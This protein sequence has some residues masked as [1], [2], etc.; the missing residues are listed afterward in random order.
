MTDLKAALTKAV[1]ELHK[2]GG[3]LP[4][5]TITA[6][7]SAGIKTASGLARSVRGAVKRLYDNED[8]PAF[9]ADMYYFIESQFTAAWFAGMADNGLN[10]DEMTEEWA[11]YLSQLIVTEQ[12]FIYNFAIEIME[13]KLRGNPVDQFLTRADLWGN[14]YNEIENEARLK[15]AEAGQKLVWIY[16]DTDHCATCEA[17]NGIVAFAREWDVAGVKPQN[18]PNKD[19]TCGG[20]RCQCRLEPTSARHTRDAFGK[21]LQAASEAGKKHYGPGAHPGTGTSQDVH[22]GGALAI[23]NDSSFYNAKTESAYLY[24]ENGNL[25]FSKDGGHDVPFSKEEIA[26]MNNATL[27]HNHPYPYPS[28]FSFDDISMAVSANL[29]EIRAASAAGVW[30]FERPADGWGWE[31]WSSARN[32]FYREQE[33]WG[34]MNGTA[35]ETEKMLNHIWD[36]YA[37]KIGAHHYFIARK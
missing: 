35:E 8:M 31:T 33:N 16:G 18:A 3:E 27:T 26:K 9:I 25:V 30:V 34:R 21:I 7:Y 32:F 36:K 19:L 13:A 15:T 4:L 1:D 10:K 5:K 37:E 2:L 11:N 14:R 6:L 17:L 29:R 23:E 20:W 24:D 28:D 12:G 22:G